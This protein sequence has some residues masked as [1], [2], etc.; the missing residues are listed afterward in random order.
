MAFLIEERAPHHLKFGTGAGISPSQFVHA[1][2][3]VVVK[4]RLADGILVVLRT[5]PK[6]ALFKT[7]NN[8][9]HCRLVK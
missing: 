9:N 3:V 6:D 2:I 5:Y 4:A 8:N 1:T 7:G